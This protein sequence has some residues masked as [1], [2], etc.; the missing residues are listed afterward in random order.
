MPYV[1]SAMLVFGIVRL[2]FI[3]LWIG[4]IVWAIGRWRHHPRV[5]LL[6][7]IG[8]SAMILNGLAGMVLPALLAQVSSSADIASQMLWLNAGLS[9]PQLAAWTCLLVATFGWR[10]EIVTRTMVKTNASEPQFDVPGTAGEG[11]NPYRAPHSN[12]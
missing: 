6:V 4:G 5:S 9:I 12:T 8:L 2:L 11:S 7:V 10:N 1:N 3:M